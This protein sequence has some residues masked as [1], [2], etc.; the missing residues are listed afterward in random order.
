MFAEKVVFSHIAFFSNTFLRNLKRRFS[1]LLLHFFI[2]HFTAFFNFIKCKRQYV[3][4]YWAF[5]LKNNWIH[6][7]WKISYFINDHSRYKAFSVSC[8][9]VI[10]WIN[11]FTKWHSN[12]NTWSQSIIKFIKK[13]IM[14]RA[15]EWTLILNMYL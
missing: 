8:K 7:I 14:S 1:S 4:K 6:L 5:Y 2:L 15:L 9:F 12:L 10:C 3:L 11:K 13:K